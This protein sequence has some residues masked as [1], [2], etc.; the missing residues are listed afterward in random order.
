MVVGKPDV[1]VD[2][3]HGGTLHQS[4]H[5]VGKYNDHREDKSEDLD[6][7]YAPSHSV[8]LTVGGLL[9]QLAGGA[10]QVQVNSLHGQGIDRLSDHLKVEAIASDGLIEAATVA[11]AKAFALGVQWHPEWKYANDSLSVAIFRAFG[12]ACRQRAIVRHRGAC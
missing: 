9:Q 7:Q 4:V 12:E 5:T 10:N 6:V 3:I 1:L 2:A 11:Y 8:R